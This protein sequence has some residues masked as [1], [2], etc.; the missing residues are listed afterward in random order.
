MEKKEYI[1]PKMEIFEYK[2]DVEFLLQ[3]SPELNKSRMC[4]DDGIYDDQFD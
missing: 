4:V 1:A 3:G 2:G